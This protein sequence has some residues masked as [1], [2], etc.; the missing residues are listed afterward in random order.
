[1]SEDGNQKYSLIFSKTRQEVT[2]FPFRAYNNQHW[3][4]QEAEQRRLADLNNKKSSISPSS[5]GFFTVRQ[6]FQSTK[7]WLFLL[8]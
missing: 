7:S 1:M 5:S 6:I 8:L 3:L 4:I 2:R